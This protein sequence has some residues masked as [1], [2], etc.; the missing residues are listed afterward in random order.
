VKGTKPGAATPLVI[1]AVL[2]IESGCATRDAWQHD[3]SRRI[4]EITR[5]EKFSED[6]PEVKGTPFLASE[7]TAAPLLTSKYAIQN[8]PPQKRSRS[9]RRATRGME[10][11]PSTGP[12][13]AGHSRG[14]HKG[15][16]GLTSRSAEED[17]SLRQP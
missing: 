4:A 14:R 3:E 11:G 13:R 5:A 10:A 8:T 9:N 16:E 17:S 7:S 12:K 6:L 1:V 2:G 15:D